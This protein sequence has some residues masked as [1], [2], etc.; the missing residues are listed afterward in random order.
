M[1]G[2]KKTEISLTGAYGIED[3]VGA[4]GPLLAIIFMMLMPWLIQV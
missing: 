1:L 4:V 2:V 3:A